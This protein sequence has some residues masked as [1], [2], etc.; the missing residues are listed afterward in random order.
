MD[1]MLKFLN[2]DLDLIG[3]DKVNQRWIR[4]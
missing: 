3:F 4:D 1:M 2:I